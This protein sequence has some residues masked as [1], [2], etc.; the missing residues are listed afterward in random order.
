MSKDFFSN[1]M[2]MF[3]HFRRNLYHFLHV[4]VDSQ[5]YTWNLIA[6]PF[7]VNAFHLQQLNS[8]G[9]KYEII[10]FFCLFVLREDKPPKRL[11]GGLSR[12][13]NPGPLAPEAR[14]IPLDH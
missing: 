1:V 9:R 11:S 13:L 8:I 6:F 4:P 3:R 2:T 10:H 7:I 5:T 14:I 12:D